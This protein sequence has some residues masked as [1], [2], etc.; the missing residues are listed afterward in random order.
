MIF[1]GLTAHECLTSGVH[2]NGFHTRCSG[3]NQTLHWDHDGTIQHPDRSPSVCHP[4]TAE[5]LALAE[6]TRRIAADAATI[7]LNAAHARLQRLE[8]DIRSGLAPAS[9]A[10]DVYEGIGAALHT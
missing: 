1:D 6:D 5:S 9:A 2:L 8:S 4:L 7:A 10:T 3:C